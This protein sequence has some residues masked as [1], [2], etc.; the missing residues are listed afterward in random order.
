MLW[1]YKLFQITEKVKTINRLK[2]ANSFNENYK[3][4]EK[5]TRRHKKWK[6]IP[7]L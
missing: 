7:C 5:E 1:S 4:L 2:V 6:A 3:M